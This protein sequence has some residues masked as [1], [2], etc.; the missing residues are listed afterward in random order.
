MERWEG[1]LGL[2]RPCVG[3]LGWLFSLIVIGGLAEALGLALLSVLIGLLVNSENAGS[4][5]KLFSIVREYSRH[6]S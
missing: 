4:N 2:L 1:P 6:S 3:R 5:T